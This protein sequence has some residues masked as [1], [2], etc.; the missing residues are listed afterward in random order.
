MVPMML[1]VASANAV[2]W[3]KTNQFTVQWDAVTTLSDGSA[4][5]SGSSIK[6]EIFLANADT[7]AN[8]TNPSLITATPISGL[9]YTLTLNT[10]GRFLVGVRTLRFDSNNERAAESDIGWSD[11]INIAPNPFGI[12]YVLIPAKVKNLR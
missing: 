8:K 2:D 7:D 3:K 9:S 11:D 4:L 1:C 5:P 6:Y 12:Y 10:E